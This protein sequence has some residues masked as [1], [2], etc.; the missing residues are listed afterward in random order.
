[1]TRAPAQPTF[2]G[3]SDE[4]FLGHGQTVQAGFGSAIHFARMSRP[5]SSA[6]RPIHGTRG[7]VKEAPSHAGPPVADL[8]Y[9]LDR[10]NPGAE[11][12]LSFV[13]ESL[14]IVAEAAS[15]PGLWERRTSSTE[16]RR[17]AV[18]MEL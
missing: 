6:V 2:G 1:M 5:P 10:P 4:S 16:M 7:C 15:P 18:P 9:Y 12:V 3:M 11:A 14:A 17:R 13:L 8:L